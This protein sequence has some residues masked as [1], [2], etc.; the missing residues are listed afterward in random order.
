MDAKDLALWRPR[1]QEVANL[2]Y[3]DSWPCF[4]RELE[5]WRCT[6][7]PFDKTN[8]CESSAA[9]DFARAWLARPENQLPDPKIKEE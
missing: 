3:G 5:G 2:E 8:S 9:P 1:M 4:G 6:G 7:C